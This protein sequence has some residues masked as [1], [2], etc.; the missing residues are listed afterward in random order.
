[1]M[2]P[3]LAASKAEYNREIMTWKLGVNYFCI[4][5]IFYEIIFLLPLTTTDWGPDVWMEFN[6]F[7]YTR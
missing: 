4:I 5:Y 3:A 7:I 2:T 6:N 1:M